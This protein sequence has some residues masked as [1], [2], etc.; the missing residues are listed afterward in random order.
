MTVPI[1]VPA[2][3]QAALD[4]G[5]MY[6]LCVS[7]TLPDAQSADGAGAPW[8]WTTA[9]RNVEHDGATHLASGPVSHVE[10]TS[11]AHDTEGR[12]ALVLEDADRLWERRLSAAGP[13]GNAARLLYLLP[14]GDGLWWPMATFDAFTEAAEPKTDPRRGR[15]LRLL[16]EDALYRAKTARGEYATDGHQ[17]MLSAEAGQTPHDNS[18]AAAHLSR[19]VRWHTR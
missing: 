2:T 13:R 9:P 8:R 16:L 6:V 10:Y 17:R 12:A 4:G 11:P 7:L 18:H 15:L 14:H 3:A 19:Q 1:D 5:A